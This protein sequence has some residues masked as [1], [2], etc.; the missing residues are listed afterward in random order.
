MAEGVLSSANVEL[1]NGSTPT[2][3][4]HV[5]RQGS[6]PNWST[7]E[8]PDTWS[9][10]LVI[11]QSPIRISA[12]SYGSFPLI[13]EPLI[14]QSSDTTAQSVYCALPSSASGLL[15]MTAGELS[16]KV[17]NNQL[18]VRSRGPFVIEGIMYAFY[19]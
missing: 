9:T 13:Y 16:F 17:Q 8:G 11:L 4:K 18:T 2:I 5:F 15:A 6:T 14:I 7:I 10:V 19:F 3:I 1:N 12:G